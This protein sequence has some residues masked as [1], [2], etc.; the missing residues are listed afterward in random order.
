M[1]RDGIIFCV[2]PF[3][4][5]IFLYF[6]H[7]GLFVYACSWGNLVICSV[8]CLVIY[9]G[10]CLQIQPAYSIYIIPLPTDLPLQTLL[11]MD[12]LAYTEWLSLMR[13]H[14]SHRDH[15]NS[16][17]ARFMGVNMAPT[18][19]RQGPGRHH[20]GPMNF[21]IWAA[22]LSFPLELFVWKSNY[23]ND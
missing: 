3:H 9:L 12:T 8:I 6:I 15:N 2:H 10:T 13:Y 14:L 18:W 19:G 11:K 23:S 5:N 17:I 20:V 16:Q 22:P 7:S 4:W 1:S 21:A